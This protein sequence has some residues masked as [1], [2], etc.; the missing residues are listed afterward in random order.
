MY[1]EAIAAAAAAAPTMIPPAVVVPGLE[2][3]V[4]GDYLAYYA[5]G[6]DET[7]AGE[8]RL[9][10]INL[11]DAF[12]AATGA[13]KIIVHNTAKGCQKGERYLI[14]TVKPYQGQRD[15][16]RKPKNHG[17]LQDWLMSYEGP[18]FRTKNWATREADDGIAACA[19]YAVGRNPGYIAIAT[20]D[21]D[22]RMLPGLHIDW[23][24]RNLVRVMPGAYDVVGPEIEKIKAGV[25]IKERGKQYGL[26]FFFMQLLMGDTADNCPGLPEY[27]SYNAKSETTYKKL[28]EKTAYD[29]LDDCPDILSAVNQVCDLYFEN[30]HREQRWAA[31]RGDGFTEWADR[32]AEQAA[33]MWMRLDNAAS[34]S[35]FATHKGHSR[36]PWPQE[37]LAAAQRLEERVKLARQALNHTGSNDDPLCADRAAA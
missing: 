10:A 16:G 31:R 33:L 30:Y 17:Y 9:N 27:R 8:S 15:T 21:K 23:L 34:V 19:H 2:L 4:D 5:A 36:I 7:T 26:K 28:G 13:T 20:A 11:L 24:K 3:H 32:L 1:E 6:N 14:A 22:L 35:D 29:L 37:V 25:V 18:L 12:R